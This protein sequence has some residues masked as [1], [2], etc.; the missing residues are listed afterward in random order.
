MTIG[1]PVAMVNSIAC[2]EATIDYPLNFE[3][4]KMLRAAI[5]RSPSPARPPTEGR[6]LKGRAA[7][8][9]QGVVS[10]NNL[11]GAEIDPYFGQVIR[12]QTPPSGSGSLTFRS[13]PR[14]CLARLRAAPWTRQ[15]CRA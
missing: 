13:S 1:K 14:E 6:Y 8:R 7:P 3:L 2:V 5:L 9:S 15:A 12:E 4:P 11:R 10:Q